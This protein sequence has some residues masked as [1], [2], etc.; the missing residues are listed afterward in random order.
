MAD[1]V[2][3]QE[4]INA[5]FQWSIE[6][7]LLFNTAKCSVMSYSRALYP[8]HVQYFLGTELIT[9]VNSVKDLGVLFDPQL[10]FHE[11][12]RSIAADSYRRLGFTIQNMREFSCPLAIKL[13]YPTKNIFM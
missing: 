10:T 13:V 5:V 8:R 9:R 11:H 6:N 7:K 1:T 12:M 4:D 3:L 2:S